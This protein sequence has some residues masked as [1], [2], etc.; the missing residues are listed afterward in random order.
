V[1]HRLDRGL[2]GVASR[3]DRATP[4]AHGRFLR[5]GVIIDRSSRAAADRRE[6]SARIVKFAAAAALAGARIVK[7]S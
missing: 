7:S 4:P 5:A 1:C 6:K 3:P 2:A